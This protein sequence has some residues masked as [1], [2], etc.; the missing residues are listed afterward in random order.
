MLARK[1]TANIYGKLADNLYS[2]YA[3]IDDKSR[4]A[5]ILTDNPVSDVFYGIVVAV[6]TPES[7][8]VKIIISSE[9]EIYYQPDIIKALSVIKSFVPT[10]I[11]CL[12]EKSCGA[13]VFR[14]NKNDVKLL[15]VKNHN[16][17]HWSFPK[18]HIEENESE[19]E[20]AIREI[21]EETNLDVVIMDNFRE[22][23]NYCPFGK[24]RKEVVFFLARTTG[25]NI[26]LQ[27]SE[28]DSFLWVDIAGA[29][30]LCSY[31]NDFNLIDKADDYIKRFVK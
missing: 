21:K 18:G 16:G 19:E 10:K 5:F 17:R 22:V 12:Y 26:K 8:D 3:N 9:K 6:V 28:I 13:V 4:R 20:T 2:G 14:K 24:I 27:E 31:D 1:V 7:G 23:S 30:K 15:L 11:L 29:K 25:D